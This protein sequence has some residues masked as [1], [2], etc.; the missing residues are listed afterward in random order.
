M[1]AFKI[2]LVVAL[3]S[4]LGTAAYLLLAERWQP[5]PAIVVDAQDYLPDGT[6]AAVPIGDG[7]NGDLAGKPGGE[8]PSSAD[9][10]LALTDGGEADAVKLCR[11]NYATLRDQLPSGGTLFGHLRSDEA[12]RSSLV[13]TPAGFGGGNCSLIHASAAGALSRMLAAARADDPAVARAMMGISCYRSIERQAALFCNADR[14]A[15]RGYAGQA[16]WVAPPGFSEHSTGLAIDFG[17][18]NGNCNLEQCF[19]NDPVGRWL[20]ENARRFG[21]H[22]SFP[23]GNPQGVSFE[24]WHYRYVGGGSGVVSRNRRISEE[25]SV[26]RPEVEAPIDL[27]IQPGDEIFAPPETN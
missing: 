15:S 26:V 2:L 13:A 18:R 27:P 5:G 23:E 12:P 9:G 3:I 22:L 17:S 4:G 25:E 16:R 11:S 10:L 20:K 7:V 8:A 24:P 21:F 14:I 19:K 6:V 1:R